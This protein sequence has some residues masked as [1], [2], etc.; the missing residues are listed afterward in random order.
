MRTFAHAAGTWSGPPDSSTSEAS[1]LTA[2]LRAVGVPADAYRVG[3][4]RD[5]AYCLVHDGDRFW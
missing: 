2:R 4:D 5:E 3:G 1:E